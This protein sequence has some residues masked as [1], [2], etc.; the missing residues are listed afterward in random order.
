MVVGCD[1]YVIGG[2]ILYGWLGFERRLYFTSN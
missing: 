1:N 2:G